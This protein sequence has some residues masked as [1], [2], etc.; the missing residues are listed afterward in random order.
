M[1]NNE[2]KHEPIIWLDTECSMHEF[3]QI[4]RAK[5]LT[6]ILYV[7]DNDVE[8]NYVLA[9]SIEDLIECFYEFSNRQYF[10]IVQRIEN[11]LMY[12]FHDVFINN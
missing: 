4:A 11:A 2:E 6:H 10:S 5:N 3:F 8:I 12:G 7:V 1:K 9:T